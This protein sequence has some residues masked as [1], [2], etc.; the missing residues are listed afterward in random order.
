MIE[1]HFIQVHY[2]AKLNP[3]LFPVEI[4][5]LYEVNA[6]AEKCTRTLYPELCVNENNRKSTTRSQF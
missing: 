1:N 2:A 5:L 3:F 4:N 6:K